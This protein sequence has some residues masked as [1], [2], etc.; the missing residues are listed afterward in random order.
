[1][2]LVRPVDRHGNVRIYFWRGIGH[3]KIRFYE[4]VGSPEFHRAYQAAVAATAATSAT[5]HAKP[6]QPTPNTYRW[7]CLK[8]FAS[9]D[10]KLLDPKTQHVRRQVLEH[11]WDEPTWCK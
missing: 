11:T 5:S 3:R 7:L 1:M 2:V 10:F 9:T 6:R 4:K 8:F